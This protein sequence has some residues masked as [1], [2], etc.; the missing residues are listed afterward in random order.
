MAQRGVLKE[1]DRQRKLKMKYAGTPGF[2]CDPDTG[3][4]QGGNPEVNHAV[5]R[6][7]Q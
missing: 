1:F 3:V 6:L 7:D 4:P 5:K 2:G